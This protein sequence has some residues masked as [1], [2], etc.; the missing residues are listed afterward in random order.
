M[1]QIGRLELDLQTRELRIDGARVR[2][3]SRAFDILEVLVN[4][5]GALVSKEEIFRQVWPETIV[6]ENNLQVHMSALRKTLGEDRDL[7]IT[8]PGRGYRFVGFCG[9]G[10]RP[11]VAPP[12]KTG[13]DAWPAVLHNLPL[14]RSALFGRQYAIADVGRLL[15]KTPIVT[16]VGAGGIGKTQLGIEVSRQNAA[17]FPDGVWLVELASLTE[18]RL[19]PPAIAEACGLKFPGGTVTAERLGDALASRRMLLLLDNCEHLV[20]IVA[21]VAET[22]IQRHSRLRLLVTSREPLR[23]AGEQQYAVAPLDV[24]PIDAQADEVLSSSAVR[25]FLARAHAVEP[26]LAGDS[27]SIEQIGEVCRRLDGIPLPI[28][29]AA[30]RA[31]TLGVASLLH[32]LD[33]RLNL[34]SGGHRTALPRHQTLRA[35]FDWS[36]AMLDPACQAVFR[37]L[38]MFTGSFT[39]EAACA[40]AAADGSDGAGTTDHI[41]ELVEKS[42]LMRGLGSA[43][44]HFRL[45]ESTRSYAFDRLDHAGE[46]RML[47]AAHASYMLRH[48]KAIRS[49]LTELPFEHA[50]DTL[51]DELDD[52]RAAIDWALSPQ[53]DTEVGTALSALVVPMMLELALAEECRNRAHPA[54]AA[55]EGAAV[56]LALGELALGLS[57]HLHSEDDAARLSVESLLSRFGERACDGQDARMA[58]VHANYVHIESRPSTTMPAGDGKLLSYGRD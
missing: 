1:I 14:Q 36:Y 58:D 41:S 44:T 55:R 50:R 32:R 16:L 31:A 11:A 45:L 57:L 7:I 27:S 4:A 23:I 24:P 37:R 17:A 40:V 9:K 19:V 48:L 10:E 54:L 42:L 29:L 34:L 53:G 35:T 26:R 39:L 49:E 46:R 52:A 12:L 25:L 2:M 51:L 43:T 56:P 18:P 15:A 21:R 30:S 20:D 8:V 28:E 3:G 6:E 5:Q 13:I 47:S 22:L 33:D 38:A